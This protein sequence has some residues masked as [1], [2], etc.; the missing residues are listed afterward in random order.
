DV[1][2]DLGF[3]AG[4]LQAAEKRFEPA[5]GQRGELG[6]RAPLVMH[7]KRIAVEALA[8]AARAGLVHLQPFYPRVEHV[9]LGAGLRALLVPFHAVEL[10]TGAVAL[11]APAVLGV[12]REKP[13][14]ELGETAPAGR[15]SALR[16]E[17]ALREVHFH[18]RRPGFR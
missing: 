7:R 3:A 11:G 18:A 10:E 8:V 14:V 17:G 15:A 1:A 12:E 5:H 4:E 13:R 2:R 6:D 16:G 9:V